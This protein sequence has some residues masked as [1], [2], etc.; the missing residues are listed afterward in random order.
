MGICVFAINIRVYL[1]CNIRKYQLQCSST[2][3]TLVREACYL[4][5]EGGKAVVRDT[6]GKDREAKGRLGV[7]GHLTGFRQPSDCKVL[8]AGQ[9]G[10]R[11]CGYG[12]QVSQ[13]TLLGC[14][15]SQVHLILNTDSSQI[16]DVC[17]LVTFPNAA[18]VEFL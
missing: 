15:R 8:Q 6:S 12:A 14:G 16:L 9:W 10:E 11:E 4:R 3:S 17:V 1:I 13:L 2:A 5:G 7:G 18:F